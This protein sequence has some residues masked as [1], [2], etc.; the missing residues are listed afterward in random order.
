MVL[1]TVTPQDADA[2][3]RAG[4]D[5][6]AVDH[7]E[8]CLQA[9]SMQDP[10][11]ISAAALAQMVDA[12]G[13]FWVEPRIVVDIDTHGLGYERLRQPSFQGIRDDL[14]PEDLR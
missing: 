4:M 9:R 13:T 3:R 1:G 8:L 5:V 10:V 6:V 14:T 2:L 12:Q 7:E 11:V